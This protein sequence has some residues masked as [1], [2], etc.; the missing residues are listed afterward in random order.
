MGFNFLDEKYKQLRQL[1]AGYAMKGY[2]SDGYKYKM[3]GKFGAAATAVLG[4]TCIL[5]GLLLDIG[6]AGSDYDVPGMFN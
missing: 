1:R 4:Y 3:R 5:R 6:L 2:E